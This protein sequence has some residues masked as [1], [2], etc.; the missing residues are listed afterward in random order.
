MLL[1]NI[2]YLLYKTSH[3]K[4]LTPFPTSCAPTDSPPLL[5]HSPSQPCHLSLVNLSANFASYTPFGAISSW[6]TKQMQLCR[7]IHD[8]YKKKAKETPAKKGKRTKTKEREKEVENRQCTMTTTMTTCQILTYLLKTVLQ[9]GSS[10]VSSQWADSLAPKRL[11]PLLFPLSL[12][13]CLFSLSCC[14][15]LSSSAGC[16]SVSNIINW[17]AAHDALLPTTPTSHTYK[18]THTH[19]AHTS[20]VLLASTVLYLFQVVGT[21]FFFRFRCTFAAQAEGQTQTLNPVVLILRLLWHFICCAQVD[22][23]SFVC[24]G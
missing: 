10:N 24:A 1:R 9:R 13:L 18:H 16:G 4:L 12:F 3:C 20:F 17:L 15:C 21:L 2:S 11:P 8:E 6:L 14:C 19:L 23:L 22:P 5:F 7:S